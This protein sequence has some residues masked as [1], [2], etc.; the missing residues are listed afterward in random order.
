MNQQQ[1]VEGIITDVDLGYGLKYKDLD[2]MFLKLEIQQFDGTPSTQLFNCDKISKIL[3]QFKGQYGPQSSLQNLYHHRL[4][5]LKENGNSVT[6]DAIAM[7]P[8][9][10]DTKFEWIYNNNWD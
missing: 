1:I 2:H 4:Y 9:Q 10:G 3:K 6:A 5:L 7:L 8:P